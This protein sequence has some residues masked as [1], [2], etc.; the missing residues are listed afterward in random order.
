MLIPFA[1]LNSPDSKASAFLIQADY[2]F[3]TLYAKQYD[4]RE[5]LPVQLHRQLNYRV[6]SF[7]R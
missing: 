6:K 4:V 7:L 3:A 5:G 2:F 1:L